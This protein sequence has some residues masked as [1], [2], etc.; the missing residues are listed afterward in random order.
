MTLQMQAKM[1]F[2]RVMDRLAEM[3]KVSWK[4]VGDF[5]KDV[6]SSDVGTTMR[7]SRLEFIIYNKGINLGT[8]EIVNDLYIMNF[9]TY[10]SANDGKVETTAQ[11]L[12][13]GNLV[14]FD[15]NFYEQS[16]SCV[17]A[18]D[19]IILT[20]SGLSLLYYGGLQDSHNMNKG[21]ALFQRLSD[22]QAKRDF[23]ITMYENIPN[24][25]NVRMKNAMIMRRQS[26]AVHKGFTIT[27]NVLL[28]DDK[29]NTCP[30]C[31]EKQCDNATLECT[32]KFCVE[33]LATHME[34]VGDCHS[35]CPLCRQPLMLKLVEMT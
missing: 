19:Q 3:R 15:C 11:V 18:S 26:L 12:V 16:Y 21:I 32:H 5:V 31:Y 27:G 7:S 14:E 6:I 25:N 17:F 29:E 33:C 22:L 23:L 9:I 2:I 20:T 13:D 28:I 4:V 8:I 34:R 1:Q 10:S 24:D 30:I 35:K